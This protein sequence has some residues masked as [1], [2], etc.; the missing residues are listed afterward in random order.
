MPMLGDSDRSTSFRLP[1]TSSPPAP[2]TMKTTSS[3]DD[4]LFSCAHEGFIPTSSSW[5][6]CNLAKTELKR[7]INADKQTGEDIPSPRVV[8]ETSLPVRSPSYPSMSAYL[9]V[10]VSTSSILSEAASQSSSPSKTTEIN[11][12][13]MPVRRRSYGDE[14][15]T[16]AVGDQDT[17]HHTLP[18]I[19]SDI[20]NSS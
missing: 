17:H 1:C 12:Q 14:P 5:L 10:L 2:R 9:P 18:I 11:E 15:H 6:G 8:R 7:T 19:V 20:F 13:E 4:L 3:F 16:S